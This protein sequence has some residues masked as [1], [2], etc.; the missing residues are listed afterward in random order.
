M[1]RFASSAAKSLTRQLERRSSLEL[2]RSTSELLRAEARGDSLV[3]EPIGAGIVGGT[4]FTVLETWGPS[5][6]NAVVTSTPSKSSYRFDTDSTQCR[7]DIPNQC[8]HRNQ[9]RESQ[10]PYQELQQGP[11]QDAPAPLRNDFLDHLLDDISGYALSPASDRSTTSIYSGLDRQE[12]KG[13]PKLDSEDR[14]IDL[15]DNPFD[16]TFDNVSDSILS[17]PSKIRAD[18]MIDR[19]ADQANIQMTVQT[20]QRNLSNAIE[21]TV[22]KLTEQDLGGSHD[23]PSESTTS[24]DPYHISNN[25]VFKTICFHNDI[26]PIENET[27]SHTE[28]AL[29]ADFELTSHAISS[30]AVLPAPIAHAGKFDYIGTENNGRPRW[31]WDSQTGTTVEATPERLQEGYVAV[32][33]TWGRFRDGSVLYH[34]SGT[35]WGVPK[36]KECGFKMRQLKDVLCNVPNVR[37]FWVD[38]LCINQQ[39]GEERSAEIAKQGSIFKHAKSTLV[40][41]WTLQTADHL[42]RAMG[43][44]GDVILMIAGDP[45]RLS[46]HKQYADE[47]GSKLRSDYW[48]S[49]LWAL[50]EMVL[51]PASTWITR[52]GSFCQL[53]GQ[54]M[55][56]YLVA[57]ALRV[58]GQLRNFSPFSASPDGNP[59][60]DAAQKW[61]IWGLKEASLNTCVSTSRLNILLAGTQRQTSDPCRGVAI[62]AA[63]KV[64]F[65]SEFAADS[66]ATGGMPVPLLNE[67]MAHEGTALFDCE[68]SLRHPNE[69]AL[70]GMLPTTADLIGGFPTRSLPCTGWH[71][72]DSG[73]L[74]IPEGTKMHRITSW[75]E[76]L[77]FKLQDLH[78]SLPENGLDAEQAI[79]DDLYKTWAL[80]IEQVKFL[81]TGVLE[82]EP[83]VQRGVIL[84]TKEHD[85][86]DKKELKWHKA[87]IYY[88]GRADEYILKGRIVV[89]A[90]GEEEKS[91]PSKLLG[92]VIP[93]LFMVAL[94]LKLFG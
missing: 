17:H 49:S 3:K 7:N 51:A 35:P 63:L 38:V 39:K 70:T 20:P 13:S 6:P 67:L 74:V 61:L 36:M 65:K 53:N 12:P 14:S 37:Y 41:L 86:F 25:T 94:A 24:D 40:Y 52:D 78:V 50:Q 56:T 29:K 88:T 19:T 33:Y 84:V 4:A 8:T 1:D 18:S 11:P 72:W 82:R 55:T 5:T 91:R 34:E 23:F 92:M 60:D 16:H 15:L 73:E 44:L 28:E 27:L 75:N 54:V 71:Y 93:G 76:D 45:D 87:G 2:T 69:S 22:S 43:E 66:A 89:R 90:D 80:R 10:E 79:R 81:P 57:G 42:A 68:H 26:F 9:S 48:F 47:Y 77:S 64:G 58:L 30:L 62:L 46:T 83:P 21:Q 85:A 31:L 59:I 32:S